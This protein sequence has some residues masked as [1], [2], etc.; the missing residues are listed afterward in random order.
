MAGRGEDNS[1][2]SPPTPETPRP[3]RKST[4]PGETTL[5]RSTD[6]RGNQASSSLVPPQ[7]ALPRWGSSSGYFIPTRRRLHHLGVVSRNPSTPRERLLDTSAPHSEA[8]T[9]RRP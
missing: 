4:A 6:L 1:N 3:R 7:V 8:A 2:S 5:S 9:H